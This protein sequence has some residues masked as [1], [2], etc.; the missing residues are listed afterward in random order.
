[1]RCRHCRSVFR[2][3]TEERFAQIHEDAF[4]DLGHIEALTAFI[5]DRPLHAVWDYLGLPGRSVLEIG[6]GSGHLL[7]A[8]RDAGCSV[9]AVES[10]KVHR[11][12][13]RDTWGIG[14]VYPTMEEIPS[15]RTFDTVVIINVFEH[16]YDI[17]AFLLAVRHVLA[18]GGT[19]YISTSNA[20][21]LEAAVLRTWWPMCKVYDHV[22]FPSPAGMATAARSSG[23][24]VE[25][26]WTTAL[27]FEFPVSALA[28]VRDR[29]VAGRGAAQSAARPPEPDEP[30]CTS[31]NEHSSAGV[32]SA[33]ARFYAAA[34]PF[35]PVSRVL[36]SLGLAGSVKARLIR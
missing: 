21:S 36:G 12:Y 22:A 34:G 35:D 23:L 30:V 2:D 33:L 13:I 28:A 29:L 26:I 27:P 15:G 25:R 31:G 5:G 6:P 16:V 17:A 20:R 32:K 24:R 19:C 3:I 14:A 7:A 4:Q 18:P 1:V 11:D 10:S 8:A 9:E